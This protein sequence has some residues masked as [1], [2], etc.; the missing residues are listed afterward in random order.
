[1]VLGVSYL[2]F[3]LPIPSDALEAKVVPHLLNMSPPNYFDG[4]LNS[5]LFN[6]EGL[7]GLSRCGGDL[8]SG[9]IFFE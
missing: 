7:S 3:L 9:S 4:G 2:L 8:I 6:P 5:Y 1:M